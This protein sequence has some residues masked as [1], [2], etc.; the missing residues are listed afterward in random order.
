MKLLMEVTVP[1]TAGCL[2]KEDAC[3]LLHLPDEIRDHV[4]RG[5]MRLCLQIDIEDEEG[6]SRTLTYME[7][8]F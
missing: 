6:N 8:F 4:M 7:D 3:T 5:A 2:G 1:S